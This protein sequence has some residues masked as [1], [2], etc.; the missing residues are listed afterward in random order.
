MKKIINYT[1]HEN[2]TDE[3]KRL[4]N[5]LDDHPTPKQRAA[6]RDRVTDIDSQKKM[7]GYLASKD[8]RSPT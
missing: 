1:Q 6:A 3:H 4:T 5:L 8:L 7:E 2:E